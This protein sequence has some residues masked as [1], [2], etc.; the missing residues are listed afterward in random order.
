MKINLFGDEWTINEH[1]MGDDYGEYLNQERVININNGFSDEIKRHVLVHELGHVI[2]SHSDY[3]IDAI[4]KLEDKDLIEHL[5]IEHF[6]IPFYE[7]LKD[8]GLR[9]K[10]YK[11]VDSITKM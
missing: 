1:P 9:K 11:S 6:V 8:E 10:L 4:K 3:I 5:I 7:I 2:E